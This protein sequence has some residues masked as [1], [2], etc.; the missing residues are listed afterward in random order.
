MS[1]M[2]NDEK[3]TATDEPQEPVVVDINANDNDDAVPDGTVTSSGDVATDAAQPCADQPLSARVE[4]LLMAGDRA[5]TEPRL[6]ELLGLSGKGSSTRIREAIDQLNHNYE[7]MGRSFRVERLA[8]GWQVLTTADFGPLLH[9]LYQDRQQSRLSQAA[10]ETL[11]II[12]YRQPII[13]AEIEAIRGVACG[14]VLRG[15]ME[16]RLIKIVGRAEELGRPM[17]YGTS[18]DFLK[19]FGLAG[20]DD[21][22][23][24]EGL[25]RTVPPKRESVI[26]E[27]T[28]PSAAA[29]LEESQGAEV[30]PKPDVAELE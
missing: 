20:L 10:L 4:A 22:P 8:G 9:R 15:L 27:S 30:S 11:A 25:Q 1:M 19:V 23:E 3:R 2:P 28:P 24:V 6:A 29:E 14:E 26:E 12:A 5:M 16:R 13:R 18:R 17:L 7:Q 21:L